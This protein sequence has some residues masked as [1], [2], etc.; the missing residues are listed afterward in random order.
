M[1]VGALTLSILA[2]A[3][4]ALGDAS[5][6]TAAEAAKDGN[7]LLASGSYADA[8]RAYTEAIGAFPLLHN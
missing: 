6:R 7:R 8:A 1:R 3:A 2:L 5:G 4:P